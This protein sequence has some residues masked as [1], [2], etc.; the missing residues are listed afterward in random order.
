[1][2]D[3]SP[4]VI[5]NGMIARAFFE[6]KF[7]HEVVI[8]A[9]GVSDSGEVRSSEFQRERKLLENV[10]NDNPNANIIYFSST[11]ILFGKDSAYSQHKK[12]M[13]E[14][15]EEQ[16]HIFHVFRLPQVVGVVLNNTL[17]SHLVRSCLEQ[18]ELEV[19][20][21]AVRNLIDIEDVVRLVQLIVNGKVGECSVQTL[22]S[23]SNVPVPLLVKEILKLLGVTCDIKEKSKGDDQTV[24]IDFLR[25]SLSSRD[26][27]FN[28]EYWR[29]VLEKY[30]PLLKARILREKKCSY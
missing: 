5:G 25:E 26:P 3:V 17:I 22:A 28:K 4:R 21:Y 2:G 11:S 13:E 29:T 15:V 24:S 1:M 18:N 9:S 19:Y 14:L 27:I 30:V 16:A 6:V 7:N 20:E 23:G 10:L 8:F 12:Y